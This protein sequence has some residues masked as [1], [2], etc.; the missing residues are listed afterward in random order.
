MPPRRKIRVLLVDDHVVVRVG[1][2]FMVNNQ[3]DMTVVGEAGTGAEA[4]EMFAKS[5]PD[6]VLMDL[7][8]PDITGIECTARLRKAD[9]AARVII[10]TTFSGDENIYRALQAG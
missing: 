2:G 8:L 7:R 3:P 9:P 6:I 1:L 5:T 10:L 4:L